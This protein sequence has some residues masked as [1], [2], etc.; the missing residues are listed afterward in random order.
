MKVRVF[1]DKAFA[2]ILEPG[3]LVRIAAEGD[4]EETRIIVKEDSGR[5]DICGPSSGIAR[6]ADTGAEAKASE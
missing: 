5:I 2:V 3:E 4:N 6:T 1:G